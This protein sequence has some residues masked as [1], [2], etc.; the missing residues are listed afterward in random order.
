VKLTRAARKSLRRKRSVRLTLRVVGSSAVGD[1]QT[2]P[3]KTLT[4]RR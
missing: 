3:A 2:L 4:L 1:P